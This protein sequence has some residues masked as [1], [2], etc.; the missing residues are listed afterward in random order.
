MSRSEVLKSLNEF[1]PAGDKMPTLSKEEL[2][3]INGGGDVQ[4]E[5]TPTIVPFTGG[6]VFTVTMSKLFGCNG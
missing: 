3:K 5:T 4:P 6:V 1:Q 2:A